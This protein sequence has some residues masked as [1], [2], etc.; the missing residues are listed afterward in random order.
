MTLLYEHG[1]QLR[2]RVKRARVARPREP[3]AL[4]VNQQNKV[5]RAAARR[6][7]R[8]AAI[9]AVLL[10]AGARVEECARLDLEDIAITAR[11]GEVCLHGKGDQVRSVPRPHR[12]GNAATNQD[13]C[14]RA[15][16][17]G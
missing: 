11:T 15:S 5:E 16:A 8:D 7:A 17:A 9:I 13:R 10:Y 12:G 4:T 14:G 1:V 6:G 2:I 3:D